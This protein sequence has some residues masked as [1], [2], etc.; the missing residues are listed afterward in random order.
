MKPTLITNRTGRVTRFPAIDSN[1]HSVVLSGCS[2]HCA[3]ISSPSFRDISRDYF[4]TEAERHFLAE[5][6]VFGTM[7]ITAA[8]P[9]MSGAY[10]VIELCRAL[11]LLKLS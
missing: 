6:A 9:I 2:A 7:L 4:D 8:V 10:A 5:A 1:Y 11:C 3:R